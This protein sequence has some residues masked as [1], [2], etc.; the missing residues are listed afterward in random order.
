MPKPNFSDIL[1]VWTG[2][3][4]PAL[5]L[6]FAWT[7]PSNLLV[8]DYDASYQADN[9][10]GT[11]F[12]PLPGTHM[13]VAYANAAAFAYANPH[14]TVRLLIVAK[15]AQ[16][17]SKW[18]VGGTDPNMYGALK[19][20]IEAAIAKIPNKFELIF[21]YWQGETDSFNNSLTWPADFKAFRDRLYAETWYPQST[22]MM[23]MGVT[24]Y[25]TGSMNIFN[26]QILEGCRK[27]AN[28]TV[29]VKTGV[30]PVE[31]W[32]GTDEGGV[33]HMKAAGYEQAGI[34]AYNSFINHIGGEALSDGGYADP[35]FG[36]FDM[37]NQPGFKVSKS[38][39]TNASSTPN[40][41]IGPWD[42]VD[43]GVGNHNFVLETSLGAQ[44]NTTNGIF[45]C[46]KAGTYLAGYTVA[47][48]AAST[49]TVIMAKNGSEVKGSRSLMTAAGDYR[50]VALPVKL[51]IGDT[52]SVV[53]V[54]GQTLANAST[55]FAQY[56]G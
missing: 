33:I 44:L 31:L 53:A 2:Q 36:T 28:R 32:G 4:N 51:A 15:G 7:P 18:L 56:L 21:G 23:V 19:L 37:P 30:L 9:V 39:S 1:I 22:V 12:Y 41:V 54:G 27:D 43:G 20:N 3:S 50:N 6:P 26:K 10:V 35:A 5:K 16:P 40:Q 46:L 11:G 45:S 13:G 55:F 38:A 47:N 14:R 49:L 29:F 8:W 52:L 42:I 24:P 48:G 34:L 25:L 17:I